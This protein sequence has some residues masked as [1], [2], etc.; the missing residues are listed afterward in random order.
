MSGCLLEPVHAD[1]ERRQAVMIAS[2][3]VSI[4]AQRL[5]IIIRLVS[6]PNEINAKK[7]WH[8]EAGTP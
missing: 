2:D 6:K 8:P 1:S 3:T 4:A 7:H 5:D